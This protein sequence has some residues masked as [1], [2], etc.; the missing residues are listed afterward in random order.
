M[1]ILGYARVSTQDQ[2]L[3][4]QLEAL[5]AAGATTIFK[6]KVSGARADRPQRAKL[7]ASLKAGDVVVVTKLD[8]L[9][10]S[11][12]ELLDLIERIG[13]AGASFRSLGDPLWDTS[14]S[15][16]RLLSTLLAAIAEFERDLIRERTGE[17][18]KRAQAKGVKFGRKPK[19]SDYQRQEAIKR[20][21]A[22]ET[23][24][25]IAKSYAVDISMISRLAE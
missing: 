24:A 9:G 3:T 11:T 12:R 25:S 4:G 23:L 18:R 6:E 16:G 21:A 19:L 1:A 22:G 5:T 8:R 7:M 2:H 15:Q 20:R 17:G 10:R 13:K 14:S